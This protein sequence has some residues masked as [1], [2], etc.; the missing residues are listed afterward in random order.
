M[1]TAVVISL[2][3]NVSPN[4]RMISLSFRDDK[5]WLEFVLEEEDQLDRLSIGWILWDLDSELGNVAPFLSSDAVALAAWEERITI[6][7]S[8]LVFEQ[9]RN[10]RIM[11]RRREAVPTSPFAEPG[12]DEGDT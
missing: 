12:I 7:K 11:Y 5:W 6:S 9:E 3:G 4:F 8:D 1:V 2:N 10:A